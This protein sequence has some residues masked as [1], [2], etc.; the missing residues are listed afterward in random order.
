MDSTL[1]TFQSNAKNEDIEKNELKYSIKVTDTDKIKN[2]D[3]HT[4]KP[5]EKGDKTADL[6]K[7]DT[8]SGEVM[9]YSIEGNIRSNDLKGALEGKKTKDLVRK[10]ETRKLSRYKDRV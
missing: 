6:Y 1:A 9:G 5:N 10:K 2:V 4:G 7:S 8:P 3:I